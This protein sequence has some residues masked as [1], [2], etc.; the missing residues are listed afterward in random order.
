ML[1]RLPCR[2]ENTAPAVGDSQ[3]QPGPG[4]RRWK[5][6]KPCL[7]HRADLRAVTG[8]TPIAA[9]I[10]LTGLHAGNGQWS[11]HAFSTL[12]CTQVGSGIY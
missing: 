2:L 1:M 5:S 9:A 4:S 10:S 8:Y 6:A 3:G 12:S 11:I 7:R